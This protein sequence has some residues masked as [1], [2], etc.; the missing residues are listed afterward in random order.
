MLRIIVETVLITLDMMCN[1]HWGTRK[2][3]WDIAPDIR[4]DVHIG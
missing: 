2:P 1:I 3:Q 4:R